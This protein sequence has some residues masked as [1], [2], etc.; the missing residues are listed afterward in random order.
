MQS[1]KVRLFEAIYRYLLYI[2]CGDILQ[3]NSKQQKLNGIYHLTFYMVSYNCIEMERRP[4]YIGIAL[5]ACARSQ[6]P[7][8]RVT[9]DDYYGYDNL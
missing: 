2:D 5:C 4:R 9:T 3:V 1:F 6:W 8:L 7:T